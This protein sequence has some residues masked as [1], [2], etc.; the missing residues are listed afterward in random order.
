MFVDLECIIFYMPKHKKQ[1]LAYDC[2][3]IKKTGLAF[4]CLKPRGGHVNSLNPYYTSCLHAHLKAD[5]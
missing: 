2:T 1:G 3:M 5:R 4:P